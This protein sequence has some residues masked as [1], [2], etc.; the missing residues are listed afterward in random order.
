MT[1]LDMYLKKLRKI[2]PIFP[3]KIPQR[4][5]KSPPRTQ[6]LPLR[7]QR[8]NYTEGKKHNYYQGIVQDVL[9]QSYHAISYNIPGNGFS[10]LLIFVF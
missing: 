5:K 2:F 7:N 10:F 4:T 9:K 3:Q 8:T 6:N 1:P